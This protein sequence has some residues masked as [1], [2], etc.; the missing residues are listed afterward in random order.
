MSSV[1]V[2]TQESFNEHR[3]VLLPEKSGGESFWI[4][5]ALLP[6]NKVHVGSVVESVKRLLLLDLCFF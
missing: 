2:L 5:V 1:A 6:Y 3:S 4:P